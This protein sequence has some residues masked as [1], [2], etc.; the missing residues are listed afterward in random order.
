MT[1]L[2][3]PHCKTH[4]VGSAEVT[5]DQVLDHSQLED[6]DYSMCFACGDWSVLH[7]GRLLRPTNDEHEDIF[8]SP[9]CLRMMHAWLDTVMERYDAIRRRSQAN[10]TR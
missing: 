10:R 3:C 6:G 9:V 7:N 1:N 2:I 8:R 5:A 4:I